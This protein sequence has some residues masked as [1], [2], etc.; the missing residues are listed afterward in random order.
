MGGG[1]ERRR[2]YAVAKSVVGAGELVDA[3]QLRGK[4]E[5]E[6]EVGRKNAIQTSR[7]MY[8]VG[9]RLSRLEWSNYTS[10]KYNILRFRES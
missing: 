10:E 5:L 8:F 7:S 3:P 4:S 1:I 2:E 9:V 6:V